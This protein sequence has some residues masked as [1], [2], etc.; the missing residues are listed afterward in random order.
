MK[1]ILA[2]I[3]LKM[4]CFFPN[5]FTLVLI[6]FNA[7]RVGLEGKPC[8]PPSS[9]KGEQLQASF[10]QTID[11]VV[12]DL[13]RS[14]VCLFFCLRER[15]F[16]IIL[17]QE[18]SGKILQDR[19]EHFKGCLLNHCTETTFPFKPVKKVWRC[20]TCSDINSF[21]GF[22]SFFVFFLFFVLF[23]IYGCVRSSFL[24]EGFL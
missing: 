14:V 24:C 7:D 2:T 19:Q 5:L 11:T 17:F 8:Y 13:R 4:L 10:R 12:S 23:I 21:L 6:L 3:Y 18:A 22:L 15:S 20:L 9:L 1:A 16:T